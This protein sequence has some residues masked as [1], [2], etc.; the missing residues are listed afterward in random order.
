MNRKRI[1]FLKTVLIGNLRD[2]QLSAGKTF[3]EMKTDEKTF[4]RS[5]GIGRPPS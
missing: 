4:P 2:L 5:G 1:Q 3:L